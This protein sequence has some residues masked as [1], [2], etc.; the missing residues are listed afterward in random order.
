M[1][2]AIKLMASTCWGLG[3][4]PKAPGTWGSLF[5]LAIVLWCGHFGIVYPWLPIILLCLIAT[6]SLAT[7][8]L[9]PFYSEHFGRHDPPQVVS[10][11]VAGQSIALV[12]MSWLIPET[13]VSTAQWIGLA[14]GA[15][16]LFRFFDIVKPGVI[17]R[18]QGVC[19]GRGV[20][21]DDILAGMIAGGL[22]LIAG[23]FIQQM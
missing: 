23:I 10:D 22:V 20:L 21:M 11:E 1:S 18:S 16:V 6:G 15:F 8:S 14:V 5:P 17:N 7:I 13:H 9:F 12:M 2:Y 19:G 4:L 3:L